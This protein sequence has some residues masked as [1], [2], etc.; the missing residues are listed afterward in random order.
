MALKTTMG[1]LF[2]AGS[3]LAFPLP[4]DADHGTRSYYATSEYRIEQMI[5]LIQDAADNDMIKDLGISTSLE[6]K[7]ENVLTALQYEES[8]KASNVL[9]AFINQIDALKRSKHL[10]IKIYGRLRA[11]AVHVRSRLR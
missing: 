5:H 11:V 2:I 7:L 10:N 8:K 3:L 6:M 9:K 1:F 4:A